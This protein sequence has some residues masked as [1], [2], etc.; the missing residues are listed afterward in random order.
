MDRQTV[1]GCDDIPQTRDRELRGETLRFG[2]SQKLVSLQE[3][4]SKMKSITR[5]ES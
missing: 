3:C 1:S 4:Q 2:V 5:T